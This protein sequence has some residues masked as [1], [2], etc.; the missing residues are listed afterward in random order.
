MVTFELIEKD[1]DHVVYNYWPENDR[2]KNPGKITINRIAEDIDLE[3]AEGDFWCSSSVEEQNCMS[4]SMN[5][6]RIE[7]GKP[8]LTEEEWPVATEE[9]RWTFC[10]SHAIHQI[11]KSYNAG[12]IPENGMEA[13]Y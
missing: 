9:M 3:L 13:W 6:V 4:Q 5:Q 12:S 2:T 7:E 1:D 11:L 10:G 8:E